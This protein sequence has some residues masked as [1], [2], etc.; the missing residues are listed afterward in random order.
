MNLQATETIVA[1]VV[2]GLLLIATTP[3][4]FNAILKVGVP[5][6]RTQA[7][8]LGF[9]IGLALSGFVLLALAYEGYME[10]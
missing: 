1:N 9:Y 6:G 7:V 2:F 5:D 4:L 8:Q 10:R 3:W